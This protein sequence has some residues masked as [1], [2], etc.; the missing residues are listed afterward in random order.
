M[1]NWKDI[2]LSCY[3]TSKLSCCTVY[4]HLTKNVQSPFYS[5]N[6]YFILPPLPYLPYCYKRITVV[7]G[8]PQMSNECHD[9]LRVYGHL[10]SLHIIIFVT[11]HFCC[12]LQLDHSCFWDSNGRHDFCSQDQSIKLRSCVTENIAQFSIYKLKA[13]KFWPRFIKANIACY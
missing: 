8:I 11:P 5:R 3:K 6:H 1:L 4:S 10:S 9:W 12:W 13:T 2:L 7:S